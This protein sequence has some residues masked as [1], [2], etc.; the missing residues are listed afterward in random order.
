MISTCSKKCTLKCSILYQAFPIFELCSI[1]F[2]NKLKIDHTEDARY[3]LHVLGVLVDEHSFVYKDLLL[4]HRS[5][6]RC[7]V[8]TRW[9]SVSCSR[10]PYPWR[11]SLSGTQGCWASVPWWRPPPTTSPPSCPRSWWT[12]VTTS[13]THSPSRLG[14]GQT[15]L[16]VDKSWWQHDNIPWLCT[17]LFLF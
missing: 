9:R 17:G 2:Y 8:R 15:V 13:T 11:L 3:I 14:K 12:S 16:S 7:W 4:Y 5:T 10:T 6:L 1:K